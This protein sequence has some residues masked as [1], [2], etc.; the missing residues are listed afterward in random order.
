[1]N[2]LLCF[3]LFTFSLGASFA[4]ESLYEANEYFEKEKYHLAIPLYNKAFLKKETA[5][6]AGKLGRCYYEQR[7][8]E[9]AKIWLDKALTIVG[10]DPK[11]N[12]Y[13]GLTLKQLEDYYSA[14][15]Y[16]D[17]YALSVPEDSL[18]AKEFA[19]SCDTIAYQLD[20][21][22]G[23]KISNMEQM[24][25]RENDFSPSK[26]GL[27]VLF[28]SDRLLHP[29]EH[30]KKIDAQSGH[31]FLSMY[32]CQVQGTNSTT[33][34]A[35]WEE[36]PYAFHEGPKCYGPD[37]RLYYTTVL[38]NRA[39]VHQINPLLIYSAEVIDG[40]LTNKQAFQHNSG[41]AS[42][43][44]PFISK[45]GERLYF[46]STRENGYG[47][48][49]LYVCE[50]NGRA[51]G[52]PKN[53]GPAINTEHDELFPYE[54]ND[55]VL[56]FSSNRPASLGGLDFFHAFKVNGYWERSVAV[57][58]PLN[59]SM[60]DFGIL[61]FDST[62]SGLFSSN[63]KGG[64]GGDDIYRFSI[65]KETTLIAVTGILKIKKLSLLKGAE[66][67][68]SM[69]IQGQV[70]EEIDSLNSQPAKNTDVVLINKQSGEQKSSKT[71][72]KGEFELKKGKDELF[73]IRASKEGYFTK[74]VDLKADSN[75]IAILDEKE[76]LENIHYNFDD[77]TLTRESLKQLD[78]LVIYLKANPNYKIIL[79]A[80]CDARGEASYNLR[81]SQKRANSV[82]LFLEVNELTTDRIEAIG[83]GETNL[84]IPNA[85]TEAEHAINRRTE[86]SLKK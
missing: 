1:M 2:K 54:K 80:Y 13:M 49:D 18:L 69:L 78:K 53:L 59:S 83:R 5:E 17:N 29:E 77:H 28:A 27:E 48:T 70:V 7:K 24:N 75:G 79:F 31:S 60:D 56:Y 50:R 43:G 3:L 58:R 9:D 23:F 10:H 38:D 19:V 16:F 14:K 62:E 67:D 76:L 71:N 32:K 82:K 47:G 81:L 45:D 42:D 36:E 15:L 73:N 33:P 64:L 68:T 74:S 41:T 12:F 6:S 46:A 34:E 65:E 63:R 66:P 8:F 40:V 52:I 84:L 85:Q 11:L 21:N 61:F 20:P 30:Q 44:H 26:F 55:S 37:G 22:N 51:W 35:L 86:F 57:G 4:Q 72:E 25:S 39:N